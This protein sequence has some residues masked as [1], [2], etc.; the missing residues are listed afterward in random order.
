[1]FFENIFKKLK[2]FIS[3]YCMFANKYSF[4]NTTPSNPPFGN[5]FNTGTTFGGES[6]SVFTVDTLRQ[7]I[8]HNPRLIDWEYLSSLN[9][10]DDECREFRQYL[11]WKTVSMWIP[12]ER[13][14]L[15]KEFINWD[16]FLRTHQVDVS[17]I[18]EITSLNWIVVLQTQKLTPE[19]LDK[20]VY[21]L[22]SREKWT[23]LCKY[24]ELPETFMEKHP[25]DVDWKAVSCF[26]KLD[27]KF[28][29]R[30][31]SRLYMPDVEYFQRAHWNLSP[32][33]QTSVSYKT[34]SDFKN[35]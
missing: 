15:L 18:A 24:Q 11:N 28:V 33:L 29:R 20:Y 22:D 26:Q 31:E 7:I 8:L 25:E 32:S 5:T 6:K 21:K 12:L 16:A 14:L 1:M 23:L 2:S 17:L 9:L 27:I 34:T 35:E 30:H 10:T 13:A 3:T 4:S 19:Q